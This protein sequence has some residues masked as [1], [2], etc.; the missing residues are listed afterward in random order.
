[1]KLLRTLFESNA[2]IVTKA[3]ARNAD[4]HFRNKYRKGVRHPMEGDWF[5]KPTSKKGEFQLLQ[6]VVD[7]AKKSWWIVDDRVVDYLKKNPK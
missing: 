4:A 5:L 1:M 3:A 6:A 7:H 2:I